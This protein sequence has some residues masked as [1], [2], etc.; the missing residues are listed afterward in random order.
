M[1][2]KSVTAVR[3]LFSIKYK[4]KKKRKK[5]KWTHQKEIPLK[6]L[7]SLLSQ[8]SRDR[9]QKNWMTQI[10]KP[11]TQKTSASQLAP[12]Q[13]LS[14]IAKKNPDWVSVL[15]EQNNWNHNLFFPDQINSFTRSTFSFQNL[16]IKVVKPT[17]S[18]STKNFQN[19]NPKKNLREFSK[20]N[21]SST[22]RSKT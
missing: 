9:T 1:L 10:P 16:V 3:I 7:L 13:L 8:S 4:E 20:P 22:S 2:T 19:K 5:K 15:S 6:A 18:R 17:T 11:K 14:P 21:N 12:K